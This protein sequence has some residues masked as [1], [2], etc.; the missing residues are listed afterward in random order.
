MSIQRVYKLLNLRHTKAVVIPTVTFVYVSLLFV[1]R[2]IIA[3]QIL[4]I[5]FSQ[6]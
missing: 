6:G 4:F 1:L 2:Y 3:F 5:V